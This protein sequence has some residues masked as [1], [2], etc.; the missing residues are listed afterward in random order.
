MRHRLEIATALV[1]SACTLALGCA[2][3][4]PQGRIVTAQSSGFDAPVL[5]RETSYDRDPITYGEVELPPKHRRITPPL[6]WTGVTLGLLG[7]VGMFT[8]GTLGI[9]T[10]SKLDDGY[11]S[12][13][14]THE[15]R[16]EF[17]NSGDLYN[18]LAAAS[19]AIMIAGFVTAIV[20]YA[21]DYTRCGPL[22][23]KSKRRACPYRA[24]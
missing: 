23:E 9:V 14:L 7:T 13:G 3:V 20:T 4:T 11:D 21:V 16:D 15:E 24:K 10:Q 19:A 17:E 1:A 6:F 18:D 2:T 5:R 22:S 12:G 8:F